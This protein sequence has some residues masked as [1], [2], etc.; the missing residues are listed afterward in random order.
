MRV[1][2]SHLAYYLVIALIPLTSCACLFPGQRDS[3]LTQSTSDNTNESQGES[4]DWSTGDAGSD[5]ESEPTAS[6]MSIATRSSGKPAGSV[7]MQFDVHRV[8]IPINGERRSLSLWKHLNESL[9]D[10]QLT[11]L[12]ARNGLRA[13]KG[14]RDAW[15]AMKSIIEESG[16][17]MG[18]Y[19]HVVDNGLSL[20]VNL[21]KTE[22][23]ESY[24]LHERGGSLKGGNLPE[25]TKRISIDYAAQDG[26]A[27]RVVLKLVP[28]LEEARTRTRWVENDGNVVNVQDNEG[29]RFDELA[30]LVKLAPGEFV[31]LG[32]SEQAD[33]GYLIGSRWLSSMLGMQKH[34]TIL[35]IRPQ[36]VRVN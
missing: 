27:T 14:D 4:A 7:H 35:F 9:G 28:E 5:A 24:F 22:G 1:D 19:R 13:G 26:D 25:G 3:S 2:R 32:S 34:E 18:T 31:V 21:D 15:P 36:L 8:E 16:G 6:G 30:V 33:N 23:G 17:R 20:L 11:A 12:L 10:P 29:I